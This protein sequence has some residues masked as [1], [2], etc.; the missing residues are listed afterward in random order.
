MFGSCGYSTTVCVCGNCPPFTKGMVR[1]SATRTH[2]HT[3]APVAGSL[4]HAVT[5]L[6]GE[7]PKIMTF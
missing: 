2:T 3:N 5:A 6:V 7:Y 1:A 4:C